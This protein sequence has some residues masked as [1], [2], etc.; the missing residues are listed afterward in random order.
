[1]RNLLKTKFI[2]RIA[3]FLTIFLVILNLSVIIDTKINAPEGNNILLISIDTLRYDS[4]GINGCDIKNITPNIDKFSKEAINFKS[5]IAQSPW[6]LPSHMTMLTSLYPL[7]HKMDSPK[8][9][10][11]H[12]SVDQSIITLAEML[13]NQNYFTAAITEGGLV[14]SKYGFSQGFITYDDDIKTLKDG[15][16]RLK[17]L[18]TKWRKKRFFIFF[19]TLEVHAP[20]IRTQYLEKLVDK[21]II[22]M[23]QKEELENFIN[24][25]QREKS[26]RRKLKDME[27]FNKEVCKNLYLAGVKYMDSYFGKIVNH[28]EKLD[29]LEN[30]MIIF[31]SDHGEEFGEHNKGAFYDLHFQGL[32][33]V[34]IKVPLI[35]YVPNHDN[36]KGKLVTTLVGIIDIMPTILKYLNIKPIERIAGVDI[37]GYVKNENNDEIY[38]CIFSETHH[39]NEVYMKAV[40][41]PE[42]KYIKNYSSL[43]KPENEGFYNLKDDPLE[44]KNLA[45]N[46]SEQYK[47]LRNKLTE[48]IKWAPE[49]LKLKTTEFELKKEHKQRLKD[50][51][52]IK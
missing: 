11:K 8:A 25:P 6:T 19:H 50:L 51:G 52:Y 47:E 46:S 42:A 44:Q 41:T 1:M 49:F 34:L 18:L 10:E 17:R 28:L 48:F 5:C 22:N 37:L 12:I 29:L 30:T 4:L 32:F 7:T 39:T 43:Y 23:D 16:C 20:Y 31:T 36:Y 13:R 26:V 2:K 45:N 3:L 24:N 38:R 40:R 21:E 15:F 33:E 9:L 35:I 14:D 27:I